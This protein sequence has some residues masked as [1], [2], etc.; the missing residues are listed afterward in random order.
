MRITFPSPSG[1]WGTV[2]HAVCAGAVISGL[3][4]TIGGCASQLQTL[5]PKPVVRSV[6]A[7][8]TLATSGCETATAADYTATEVAV[9]KATARVRA[10]TLAPAA[11]Q[12]VADAAR[13]VRAELA[14]ACAMSKTT[15]NAAALARARAA[16]VPVIQGAQQ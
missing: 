7:V 12:R 1:A 8:A 13:V 9:R 2:T 5:Q 3:A 16:M 14:S 15:P 4:L 11:A 10:G 6:Q